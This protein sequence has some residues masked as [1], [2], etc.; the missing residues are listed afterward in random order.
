MIKE[1]KIANF[2]R[3][4]KCLVTS[5]RPRVVFKSGIC[6]AC[7]NFEDR[8]KINWKKR[9]QIL[10]NICKKLRRK[11][12]KFDVIVPVGGGKDSS[13][14]AWM[15][16]YK[17]KM[18]PL[19]VFCEPPLFSNL[20]IKNLLNFES[21]GFP[22]IKIPHTKTDRLINRKMFI[23]DGLPQHSWLAKIKIAP[24]KIAQM[25]DI[26][27][28][29]WGDEGESMYGGNNKHKLKLKLD[30]KNI[31]KFY[32][33]SHEIRNVASSN[34]S[35][36]N[37]YWFTLDRQEI[38]MYKKLYNCY[39]SYFE[40]WDENKHFKI[41]R[42]YCGLIDA[43]KREENA[44]NKHSHTD[45]KMFA[46]HMYLA[47]LKYGFSRATSDTSIEIRHKKLT[48]KE[49]IKIVKKYDHIF[50]KKYTKI[51]C[52]YFNLSKKKFDLILNKSKNKKIFN[53]NSKKITVEEN[54]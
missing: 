15:L 48:R 49:A 3:C 39:W 40:R 20:G 51:Y 41:A 46:L 16:K 28:I 23:K 5:T 30:P 53:A 50:P 12:G 38:N 6:T 27:L 13:Y 11:D 35:K 54:L 42:K 26:K 8:K 21:A 29:M 43:D 36:K 10:K 45:Q 1:K 44:I 31:T 4:K 34:D 22:V 47:Y 14:V 7:L 33:E 24:M 19:C 17:L 37:Y 9:F 25:M 52:D 32:L 18:N 2:F